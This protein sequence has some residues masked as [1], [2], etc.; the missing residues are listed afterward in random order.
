[1]YKT[2]EVVNIS[3]EQSKM[4][5]E[6]FAAVELLNQSGASSVLLICEHA[7]NFIPDEFGSLGLNEDV[8]KSHIAWDPGAL[9]VTQHLSEMLD[10][11]AIVGC[12]SRLVYDCNRPP[13]AVDAV[14]V[15][16]EIFDVPGNQNL[17]PLE[18]QNRVDLCFAPFAEMVEKTIKWSKMPRIVVTIHSF[19]P[20][21]QGEIRDTDIGILHDVDR[22]LADAMLALA[23][24]LSP[25]KIERNSPYG[26][27]DGVTYTLKEHG[28]ANGLLN[29]MIEVRNDLVATADQQCKI[30]QLLCELLTR[31]LTMLG[32]TSGAEGN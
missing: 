25:M 5:S 21:Y 3:T 4:Q 2:G 32:A 28:I 24:H 13:Q 27:E 30:A 16:S 15:R 12:V 17:S 10:A 31:S 7:S 22:K 29:V 23:P 8:K 18:Y 26:P 14:P 1:M 11:Q 9:G 6:K 20:V 19:T